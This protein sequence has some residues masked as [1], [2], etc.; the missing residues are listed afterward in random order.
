[1]KEFKV[2]QLPIFEANRTRRPVKTDEKKNIKKKGATHNT[3][4]HLLD[5][6]TVDRVR[7][8]PS[9]SSEGRYP[10]LDWGTGYVALMMEL[11]EINR[12]RYERN[13]PSV[14][15]V[16]WLSYLVMLCFCWGDAMAASLVGIRRLPH[17]LHLSSSSFCIFSVSSSL[18]SDPSLLSENLFS[19]SCSS[20]LR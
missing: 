7:V 2:A 6:T 3:T 16:D 15:F 20:W 12:L 4:T 17:A 11:D 9:K 14:G 5:Q 1:V 18:N 10:M 8:S 19:W 13:L